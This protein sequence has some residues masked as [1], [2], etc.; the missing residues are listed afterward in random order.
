VKKPIAFWPRHANS[1]GR[2]G[3]AHTFAS[4]GT[5]VKAGGPGASE[6][7]FVGVVFFFGS[8][9]SSRANASRRRTGKPS[10]SAR[11]I[12]LSSFVSAFALSS[13]AYQ[14]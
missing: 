10:A 9:L 3:S 1:I 8:P 14:L 12:T 5:A 6:R 13:F 2:G 11:S 7:F 4:S